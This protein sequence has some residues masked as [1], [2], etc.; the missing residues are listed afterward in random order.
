MRVATVVRWLALM[1]TL[2]T[3]IAYPEHSRADVLAQAYSDLE[4]VPSCSLAAAANSA[5]TV[6]DSSS[7]ANLATGIL[8]A[9]ANCCQYF[10]PGF[11]SSGMA[12][13]RARMSDTITLVAPSGYSATTIPFAT[14][15]LTL[16]GA[17]FGATQSNTTY[18]AAWLN[19]YLQVLPAIPFAFTGQTV[20]GCEA[21]APSDFCG[22]SNSPLNLSVTIH[23][24]PLSS[25]SISVTAFLQ[26]SARGNCCVTVNGVSFATGSGFAD[27]MDPGE[28][29]LLLPDGFTFTSAS[30]SF[31]TDV[32]EPCSVVSLLT[33][34]VALGSLRR[35]GRVRSA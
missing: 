10:V 24:I 31:L 22:G 27:A 5:C 33:A 32:P 14:F 4:G 35:R 26:A 18:P 30:G 11:P 25:D 3:L 12:Q 8:A 13:A 9:Q 19:D 1:F 15:R 6:T 7:S 20:A 2:C 29:A 28:I 23:N 17:S 21:T 34:V 16:S